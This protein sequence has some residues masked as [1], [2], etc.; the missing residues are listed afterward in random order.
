M[1][2]R[3]QATEYGYSG[4]CYPET[5]S[6]SKS[7]FGDRSSHVQQID[8]P[9]TEDSVRSTIVELCAYAYRVQSQSQSSKVA[10]CG[11]VCVEIITT[12]LARTGT[13]AGGWNRN[14]IMELWNY[15]TSPNHG[16]GAR[17]GR[18]RTGWTGQDRIGQGTSC[19]WPTGPQK[20][21]Q[22][23]GHKAGTG[24]LMQPCS[25][26]PRGLTGVEGPR[27]D[28]AGLNLW[29]GRGWLAEGPCHD[30]LTVARS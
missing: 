3:V 22:D 4:E 20:Q 16:A 12:G 11:D 21:D 28:S 30:S 29:S 15:G 25:S 5:E 18:N 9:R 17:S 2:T 1:I 27:F 6:E 23:Q 26:H 7:E 24:I 14:G 8:A 10:Q 13:R 19:H